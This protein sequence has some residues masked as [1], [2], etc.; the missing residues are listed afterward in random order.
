MSII[1]MPSRNIQYVAISLGTMLRFVAIVL[2]AAVIYFIHDILLALLVA[3][4]VASAIDPAIE[5]L[6]R[7]GFPRILG[8]IVIY[9]AL[10]SLFLFLIYLIFPLLFEE[11]QLLSSSYPALQK[12][13]L[14]GF[15]SAGIL[16]FISFFTDNTDALLRIPSEYLGNLSGG[17]F[18]T[19]SVLFGGVFSFVLI[20]VLSF[21]LAAQEKGIETFL[22][23]VTPLAQEEYTIDLWRR[24]QGKLG[25]WLRAQLLL[26]A[27]VGICIFFGLTFLGVKQALFFAII[28]GI[29]EIIPIV[30]PILAAIPAVITAFF[31]APL[32]GVLTLVLYVAVQQTESHVIVPVVMQRAVGLSP[33]IVVIALLIGGKLGGIMGI[34]LAVPITAIIA[35]LVD[36]WDK[37]KRSIMPQ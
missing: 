20:V 36:D 29:F 17:V 11:V 10:A 2:L 3:V 27:I 1:I 21:Y 13:I 37:K 24:A 8:A 22:R 5:W 26:G 14:M 23:M 18:D 6:K 25:R 35:E 31:S 33:L 15:G 34:L 12:K 4:I 32:L 16:P 30:G 9:L 19:V 7:L 28:A